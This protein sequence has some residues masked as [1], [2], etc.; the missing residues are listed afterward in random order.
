MFPK[1]IKA[2]DMFPQTSK[3]LKYGGFLLKEGWQYNC[4]FAKG[5]VN[6][7]S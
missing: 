6:M 2:V 7:I 5:E 4:K 1:T 3:T